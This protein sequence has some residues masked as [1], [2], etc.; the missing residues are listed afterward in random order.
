MNASSDVLKRLFDL[1]LCLISLPIVLPFFLL[2]TLAIKLN[3]QGPVFY[4]GV[5]AGRNGLS[6]RIF[7]FRTMV[8]DAEKIG[9]GTTALNDPRITCEGRFLRKFKLDELPQIFNVI[10]GDMSL[11]G[12]RPELLEYA[13]LYKGEEKIIMSVRP[14]ITDYS[15]IRFSSLDERVGNVNA[16]KVFNEKVLP[17]RTALRLK[18][19]KERTFMGDIKLIFLT[20]RV[21]IGKISNKS[22]E[23]NF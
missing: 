15:S 22:P 12:P 7:K 20:F 21:I 17:E 14:G 3:S 16:N 5:R 19:V 8:V 11:V 23:V 4:R 1:S 2:I 18:Y 6:F 9:S 13:A 10:K